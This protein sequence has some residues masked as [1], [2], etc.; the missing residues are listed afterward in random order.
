MWGFQVLF[1]DFKGKFVCFILYD[2][3]DCKILE[4][5]LNLK[6]IF[7]GIKI[8][9]KHHEKEKKRIDIL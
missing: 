9:N 1:M 5:S 8:W 4:I 2:K 6:F 7:L 3:L